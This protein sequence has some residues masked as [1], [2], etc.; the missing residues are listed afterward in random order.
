[1]L[2]TLPSCQ[3]PTSRLEMHLDTILPSGGIQF[4][5]TSQCYFYRRNERHSTESLTEQ[6]HFDRHFRHSDDTSMVDSHYRIRTMSTQ[7]D[8]H[9]P[10]LPAPSGI[11]AAKDAETDV[12]VNRQHSKTQRRRQKRFAPE[13]SG[14]RLMTDIVFHAF[15]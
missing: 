7:I 12:K 4:T 8:P 10:V 3:H 9:I 1:M 13:L 5:K 2:E 15:L 6:Q 11:E 14:K